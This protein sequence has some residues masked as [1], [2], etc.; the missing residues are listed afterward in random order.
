MQRELKNSVETEGLFAQA[1]ECRLRANYYR[2]LARF[3][4]EE[5]TDKL[6]EEYVETQQVLSLDQFESP[7][8]RLLA[9]GSNLMLKYLQR[10]TPDTLTQ[11]RCDYAR[12]FLGAGSV[13]KMPVS[14]FESVYANEGRLVMQ[15]A[16]DAA[17][18]LY[19]AEGLQIEDHYNM[20]EDHLS[21]ELQYM[22]LLLDRQAAAADS[23]LKQ[24]DRYEKLAA[25][26]LENH[27]APWVPLFCEEAQALAQTAFYRGL[28][29]ATR[30][31]I[32]L[33]CARYGLDG[34]QIQQPVRNLATEYQAK[35]SA[36]QRRPDC[37]E[38]VA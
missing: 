9:R 11:T 13:T 20:P 30:A 24:A 16:R 7:A 19:A 35:A 29:Q 21:F 31:W 23:D 4:Y 26:F 18:A 6:I 22:A 2:L 1:Q 15:G 33:E 10:R 32:D 37:L 12:V 27:L 3:L 14:P 8:E 17:C 34:L 5:L 25:T 36:G 28:L 38:E